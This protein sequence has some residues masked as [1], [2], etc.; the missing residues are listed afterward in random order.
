MKET[1]HESIFTDL[2]DLVSSSLDVG[3]ELLQSIDMLMNGRNSGSLA[4]MS[5]DLVMI[6]PVI[7]SGSISGDTM[8][9]INKALEYKYVDLTRLVISANAITSAKTTTKFIGNFHYNL[10]ASNISI[11]EY[12]DACEEHSRGPIIY[13]A[14]KNKVLDNFH[15]MVNDKNNYIPYKAE[16]Q[17]NGSLL[18]TKALNDKGE[19]EEIERDLTK[20]KKY[21]A[22]SRI[23]DQDYKK[24]ND[25]QPTMVNISFKTLDSITKKVINNDVVVGI[26]AK[27]YEASGK[28]IVERIAAKKKN[29]IS[30]F[31]LIRATTSEISFW[32]DFI[33]SIKQS[34]IDAIASSRRS[35]TSK[36]WKTLERRSSL[37]KFGRL[38]NDTKALAAPITTL[39]VSQFEVDELEREYDIDITDS[40]VARFIL[41]SYNLM[42]LGIVDEGNESFRYI[43]DSGEDN[44]EFY[45]FKSLNRDNKLNYKDVINI[46]TKV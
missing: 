14:A 39:V 45:T 44:Y 12:L 21:S 38:F 26:K 36:L 4:S 1:F 43:L 25:M 5:K 31:N 46:L 30:L 41:E 22:L 9:L 7:M 24:A 37:A 15:F 11:D 27:L 6:F 42:A 17:R 20:K 23:N 3:D 2:V 33:F 35:G 29:D 16:Y 40:K 10:E 34:K 13:E 32:K 19:L 18:E 28:E 8:R